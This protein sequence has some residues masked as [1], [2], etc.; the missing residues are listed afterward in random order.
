MLR[1]IEPSSKS[2]EIEER[3]RSKISRKHR[4]HRDF[5]KD[6]MASRHGSRGMHRSREEMDKEKHDRFHGLIRGR[7]DEMKSRVSSAAFEPSEKAALLADVEKFYRLEKE[8]MDSRHESSREFERA[9]DIHDNEARKSHLERTRLKRE[10]SRDGEMAK[11]EEARAIRDRIM[12]RLEVI[13][14]DQEL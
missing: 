4:D 1:N 14:G 10:S 11:R 8:V 6:E 9:R 3:I 12:K 13:S 2:D 5:M 7:Y